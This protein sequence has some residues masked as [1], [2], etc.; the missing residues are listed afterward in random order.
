[1]LVP[2]KALLD[3]ARTGG[4]A[5]GTFTALNM[6]TVRGIVDAVVSEQAPA[7]I[8]ITR[9]MT[10]YL[11]LEGLAHYIEDRAGEASIPLSLHLDHATEL[12]LVERALRAG[13]TS[14]QYD[15]DNLT[16]AEKVVTTSEAVAMARAYGASIEAELDHI[17]RTGYET[18][19]GLTEPADAVDFAAATGIDILAVSV[20]S[21]HGQAQGDARL[22][23]PRVQQI[24]ASTDVHLALHGG[25]GVDPAQTVAAINAGITKVSYFHGMAAAAMTRLARDLPTTPHGMIATL[26]DACLRVAYGEQCRRMLDVYGAPG[27]APSAEPAL[28]FPAQ[29]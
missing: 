3:D 16:Y 28:A 23:I 20:G 11:D 9:R 24:R 25:T 13:F 18:G 17:G 29:A 22:D 5:I 10:P 2:L 8:S 27:R 15:G 26:L 7:A 6:E 21:W 14:V 12:G 1:M 4:Y 19:G